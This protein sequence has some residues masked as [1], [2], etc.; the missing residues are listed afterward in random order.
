MDKE[1]LL[2]SLKKC[3]EIGK[4]KHLHIL[5]TYNVYPDVVGEPKMEEGG[6]ASA[7]QDNM[8]Y[9]IKVFFMK[10]SITSSDSTKILYHTK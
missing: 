4:K 3:Q 1:I 6:Q 8:I 7:R 5:S 10:P 2:V 9:S